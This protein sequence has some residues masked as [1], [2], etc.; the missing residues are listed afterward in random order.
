MELL[1]TIVKNVVYL[2]SLFRFSFNKKGRLKNDH[3]VN[4]IFNSH[5]KNNYNT[6]FWE[7][8]T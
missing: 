3:V 8:T 4:I 5:R 7:N 1:Y 6:M 2:L